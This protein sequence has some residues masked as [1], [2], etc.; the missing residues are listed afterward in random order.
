MANE[1]VSWIDITVPLHMG[2][3]VYPGDAPF[4]MTCEWNGMYRLSTVTMS[5]HSGTHVDAP[6]HFYE[7]GASVDMMAYEV[8]NGPARVVSSARMRDITPNDR[9]VLI[10]SKRGLSLREADCLLSTGVVLIGVEGL[11]VG[12]ENEIAEVHKKLLSSGVV[13]LENIAIAAVEDGVYHLNCLPMLI[14]G[15]EGAPARA[16]IKKM[17]AQV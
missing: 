11:S 6:S 16:Y 2:M 5:V 9:R 13:I 3:E 10:K 4:Q 7:D 15:A 17:S 8:M 14:C 12:R 1:F